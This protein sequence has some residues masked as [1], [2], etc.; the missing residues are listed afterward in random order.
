[1][2]IEVHLRPIQLLGPGEF[3]QLGGYRS[4]MVD[5]ALDYADYFKVLFGQSRSP[6]PDQLG[7]EADAAQWI[8]YFVGDLGGHLPDG[9]QGPIAQQFALSQL[10]VRHIDEHRIRP[11]CWPAS[12]SGDPKTSNC[13][14]LA[15]STLPKYRLIADG[16]AN[17]SATAS[18]NPV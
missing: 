9:R 8:L 18:T 11:S 17:L 6:A 3:Q 7:C 1:Q 14:P 5:A 10:H 4:Q 12:F 15:I 13:R 16:D 2:Y